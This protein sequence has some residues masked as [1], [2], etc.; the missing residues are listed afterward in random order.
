MTSRTETNPSDTGELIT[1]GAPND[2]IVILRLNRPHRLNALNPTLVDA[3]EIALTKTVDEERRAVILT[4]TGRAFCAGF[5][6]KENRQDGGLGQIEGQQRLADIITALPIPVIAAING[7]AVGAG[8]EIALACDFVLATNASRFSLPEVRIGTGMGGG[9]SFLLTAAVGR[10]RASQF[11]LLGEE[12]TATRA[13][14]IG[15]VGQV[16]EPEHLMST[17]MELATKLVSRPAYAN[18]TVKAAIFR[19]ANQTF[20]EALDAELEEVRAIHFHPD[21]V[22]IMDQFRRNSTYGERT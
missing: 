20:G 2:P 8:C 6:L 16:V 7:L 15:L 14:T 11:V 13:E 4:G 3:L 9:T 10:I 5:D 21:S 1:E 17:A 18:A 19:G 12:I 22:A